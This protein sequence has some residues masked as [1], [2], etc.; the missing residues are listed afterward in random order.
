[1]A[2]VGSI[3][4]VINLGPSELIRP[5]ALREDYLRFIL[6]YAIPFLVASLGAVLANRKVRTPTA[7]QGVAQAS[8]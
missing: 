6:D 2:L 5:W 1:M 7:T 8:E 4:V 3:L